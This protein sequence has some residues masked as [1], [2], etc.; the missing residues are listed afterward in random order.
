MLLAL[1]LVPLQSLLVGF[2][3]I[4][5]SGTTLV[6]RDR[7]M[8]CHWQKRWGCSDKDDL[9][10]AISVRLHNS[11]VIGQIWSLYWKI[12]STFHFEPTSARS[13]NFC[14]AAEFE[15]REHRSRKK[16]VFCPPCSRPYTK[17]S[18]QPESCHLSTTSLRALA[19]LA[20][21][22]S[23]LWPLSTSIGI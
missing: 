5:D 17:I 19:L 4:W 13:I 9:V 18:A 23:P 3:R 8:Q 2:A 6:G 14:V 1:A 10:R 15:A 12:A 16:S 11:E 22:S 20:P 7:L 21:R